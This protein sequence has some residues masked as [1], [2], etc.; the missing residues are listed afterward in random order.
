MNGFNVGDLNF[1]GYLN[2]VY[3]LILI[4][5]RSKLI[6]RGCRIDFIMLKR[7]KKELILLE[8]I[9]CNYL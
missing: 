1:L 2:F 5:E 4:L 3:V 8:V 9:I 7:F 6:S